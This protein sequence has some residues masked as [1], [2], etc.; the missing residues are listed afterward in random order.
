MALH[1]RPTGI[2]LRRGNS[3]AVVCSH[4]ARR[5]GHVARERLEQANILIWCYVLLITIRRFDLVLYVEYLRSCTSSER[6]MRGACCGGA[7]WRHFCAHG[8]GDASQ[9]IALRLRSRECTN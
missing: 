8:T 7:V 6:A 4:P 3:A 2:T 5:R 1:H 9:C